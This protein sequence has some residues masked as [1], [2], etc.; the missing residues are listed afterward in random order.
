MDLNIISSALD[1]IELIAV[2]L[3]KFLWDSLNKLKQSNIELKNEIQKIELTFTKNFV[4][5]EDIDKNYE[6]LLKR[7]E[8]IEDK[9]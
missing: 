3:L 4:S 6:R 7:I 5:K 1:V 8:K 9:N 2:G